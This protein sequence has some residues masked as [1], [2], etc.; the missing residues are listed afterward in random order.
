M[1]FRTT[2]DDSD[3]GDVKKKTHL[4]KRMHKTQLVWCKGPLFWGRFLLIQL[5]ERFLEDGGHLD[6][7][8]GLLGSKVRINELYPQYSL[9]I[10]R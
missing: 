9:F 10:S 7:P 1:L 4:T 6:V 2:N 5:L 8:L 3:L